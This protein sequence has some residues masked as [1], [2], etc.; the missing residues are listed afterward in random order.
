MS[1][2]FYKICKT[3]YPNK[4]ETFILKVKHLN[5]EPNSYNFTNS[6]IFKI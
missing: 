5:S 2:T 1:Q 3:N 6:Q 4:H